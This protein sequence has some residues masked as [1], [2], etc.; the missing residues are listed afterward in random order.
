MEVV[1]EEVVMEVVAM[2]V[3]AMEVVVMEVEVTAGEAM[4]V[5]ATEVEV[6]ATEVEVVEVEVVV[7]TALEHCTNKIWFF[8]LLCRCRDK[9]RSQ[10]HSD[11]LHPSSLQHP[12]HYNHS[13]DN[14]YEYIL[15]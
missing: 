12:T 3:V 5:E 11:H 9:N 6:V 15:T 14:S 1:M 7:A 2:E 4:E 13:T 10:R 8:Y